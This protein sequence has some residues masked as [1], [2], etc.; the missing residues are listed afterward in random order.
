MKII[1]VTTI[2]PYKENYHGTSGIQYH[3][4][5]ERPEDVDI[6]VYSFNHNDLPEEKIA[7]VERELGV[8]IHVMEKKRWI[9]WVHKYNLFFVRVLLRYPIF[10][11]VSLTK[12]Y[13]EE[14]KG[15]NPDGIWIYG[16]DTS[17]ITRQFN[18]FKR[19]HT[20]PDCESLYYHR[21]MEQKFV[22]SNRLLYL[23][24]AIMF[25]KYVRMERNYP[26][27]EDIHYTL[28]G[29]KDVEFLRNNNKNIDA[30]FIKHPHYELYGGDGQLPMTDNVKKF[31][32]RKIRLL[33]AGQNNLYMNESAEK[34]V[35][36]LV[37]KGQQLKGG[38]SFTFLGKGWELMV[39]QLRGVG[40][41]VEH[42][43]FAPDYIE[44]IK[45][46][47]VQI[48][49]ITIGTGTKGKVLDALANGLL[50]IGTYYAMENIA[51]NNGESCIEYHE[52]QEVIDVLYEIL[53]DRETYEQMAK[54]GQRQ[55]LTE[56]DRNKVSAQ[57]FDL[58]R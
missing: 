26:T 22:K 1:L 24:Q 16:Q 2:T 4:I 42:I 53:N 7:E 49:P 29:E 25:P 34:L 52:P 30:R 12:A 3:L 20:L 47:D 6:E 45:K 54:K 44:E 36:A 13:V 18:G 8:K 55:V 37:S 5:V 46:H 41:E 31:N 10:N 21:M 15:K 50:V 14:I 19:V 11:Y 23:R 39:E 35:E 9:P 56:H 43:R 28:V 58:F 40:Y 17:R 33:I 57:M 38:Y 48:T 27:S 51:V 32:E